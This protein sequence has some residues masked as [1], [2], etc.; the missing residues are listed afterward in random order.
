MLDVLVPGKAA[1]NVVDCGG[2][3]VKFP[4]VTPDIFTRGVAQQIQLGSIGAQ[5]G[6][7]TGDNVETH[8][9]I[10]EEILELAAAEHGR[11]ILVYVLV[12]AERSRARDTGW[13]SPLFHK[14][15]KSP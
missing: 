11:V 1:Q 15:V 10:F 8:G 13:Q 7:V 2:I 14:V 5:N 4:D 6:A 12:A 3:R 9:C